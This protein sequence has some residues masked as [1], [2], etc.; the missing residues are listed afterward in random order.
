MFFK[1]INIK[2]RQL[3]G[4]IELTFQNIELVK[5]LHF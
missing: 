2:K 5:G 4:L 3:M 1:N